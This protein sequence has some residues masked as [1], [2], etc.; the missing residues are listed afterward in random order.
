M[1]AVGI[2]DVR[3]IDP[4]EKELAAVLQKAHSAANRGITL[5]NSTEL[6]RDPDFWGRFAHDCFREKNG[7][8]RS[9]KAGRQTPEVIAGWWTDPAGRRHFRVIGRTRSRYAG[10]RGE[11]ELRELPAWW[12]VYPESVIAVIGPRGVG[13]TYLA[14]CRCGKVGTPAA[15][16]WM[17]D[18]CGPCFDRRA[19]GGVPATGFGH[20]NGWTRWQP[21]VG[22]SADGTC[23]VGVSLTDRLRTANRYDGQDTSANKGGV[24][25][26]LAATA[27]EDAY[28]F[29]CA[30][31]TVFHWKGT[32]APQ[33]LLSRPQLY[34]RFSLSP[35]GTRAVVL[36]QGA[37][38]T[39][40]LSDAKPAYTRINRIRNYGTMRFSPTGDRL[41]AITSEGVLMSLDP[42]SL[43]ETEIRANLFEGVP[44]YGYLHD[45]A[46]APDAS[47]IAIIRQT[48]YPSSIVVR[49]VPLDGRRPMFDLPLPQWH[50]PNVATFSPDGI[51]I[52]TADS[53]T[54]WVG[55]WKLPTGKPL[56]YVR[57]V[58]E[59]PSSQSG[60]IVFSPD[61]TAIAVPYSVFHQD[62]GAVVAVWPWPDVMHA[63]SG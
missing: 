13:E 29:G 26:V 51:H 27:T 17:G 23:L 24:A 59:D 35:D 30:D 8:R 40:N 60:Q 53:T 49:I 9:C 32:G 5:T 4:T 14:C 61:A 45:L 37:G 46:I 31:G 44:Q 43:S 28:T 16:G 57:A 47:S 38:F 62:R 1:A 21:R 25:G 42:D 39:A 58:P 6:S 12:Q 36:G 48:H 11:G 52:I 55:F 7:R 2:V 34:G 10:I 20:I 63:A 54:G 50:R 15:L 33:R 22:F 56:G 3:L 19:D 41:F 18:T